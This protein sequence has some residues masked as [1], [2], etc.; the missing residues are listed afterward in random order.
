M[1]IIY[2]GLMIALAV[3]VWTPA[4]AVTILVE[5]R[6]IEIDQTLS[7]PTDLWITPVDLTKLNG[8]VLKP[9]GACVD[10]ICIPIKQSQDSSIFVTRREQ[11][12]INVTELA[13]RLQQAYVADH[14]SE[15]WSLG[16]IPVQRQGFVR[17]GMAPDFSLP[18][19]QGNQVSLS[20]FKGK[21]IMLLTWA[22]W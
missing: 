12:W 8:F 10:D 18:D 2:K 17:D 22:S 14:D 4:W 21:K 15:V 5:N 13:N 9:E 19:W 16:A 6:V 1:N 11:G 7:D 20:D 3:I